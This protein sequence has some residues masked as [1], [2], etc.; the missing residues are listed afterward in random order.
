MGREGE[1]ERCCLEGV[2]VSEKG[3]LNSS[4]EMLQRTLS[5][6]RPGYVVGRAS[7]NE[8]AEPGMDDRIA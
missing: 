7:W 8:L 3:G 2:M 6:W 5:S 1:G 4:W